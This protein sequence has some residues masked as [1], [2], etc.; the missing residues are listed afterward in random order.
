MRETGINIIAEICRALGSKAPLEDLLGTLKQAQVSQLDSMLESQPKASVPRVG[1]RSAASSDVLMSSHDA[2]SALKAQSAEMDA[3]RFA[4]RPRVNLF[5]KL[6]TTDYSTRILLPKWSEKVAALDVLLECGGETPYKLE[7]PGPSISYISLIGEM[8]KLINHTHF[9]VASKSMQV[10]SMLAEGVGEKLYPNLRPLMSTLL[11]L[12]KDKKLTNAVALCLDSFFGSV[13]SIDHLLDKDDSIP[14]QLDE[15]NQKNAVVRSSALEYLGR[16]IKRANDVG[17]RGQLTVQSTKALSLVAVEKLSDTDAK[18]RQAALTLL[19]TLLEL[20]DKEL[21]GTVTSVTEGLKTSNARAYKSLSSATT[22]SSRIGAATKSGATRGTSVSSPSRKTITLPLNQ[23]AKTT[24]KAFSPSTSLVLTTAESSSPEAA[25]LHDSLSRLHSLN[26]PNWSAAEDNGGILAGLKSTQ[27]LHRQC[28]IQSL[29]AFCRSLADGAT[30]TSA[31]LTVVKQYT[32]GFKDSNVNIMKSTFEL[33]V[34]LCEVH[35]K[36]ST[37]F[38]TW[39]CKDGVAAATDKVAD[40]KLAKSATALL[41]EVC[42]VNSPSFVINESFEI[43]E[44]VKSPLVHEA[45]TKWLNKLLLDFGCRALQLNI[46]NVINFLDKECQSANV[47]VKNASLSVAGELHRQYGPSFRAL[48]L[49]K[50]AESSSRNQF[51]AVFLANPFDPVASGKVRPRRCLVSNGEEISGRIGSV[52]TMTLDVPRCDLAGEIGKDCIAKMGSKEGKTA[53]KLRKEALDEVADALGNCNGMLMTT[54]AEMNTLLDLLRALKERLSDSQSNL[55]PLAARV[56][57]TILAAVDKSSQGKLG[58]VVLPSLVGAAMNDSRKPMRDES[59]QAIKIGTKAHDLEGG[60]YHA[61]SLEALVIALVGELKESE[62][63]TAGIPAVLLFLASVA[64]HVPNIDSIMMARAQPLGESFS[65]VMVNGLTS[66]KSETRAAAEILIRA[67]IDHGIISSKTVRA[68][69]QH[70]KPAQQRTVAPIVHKIIGASVP[71]SPRIETDNACSERSKPIEINTNAKEGAGSPRPLTRRQPSS[72]SAPTGLG[73][74]AESTC[75]EVAPPQGLESS[76][77]PLL[78][79][80]TACVQR[81]RR[82]CGKQVSWVEYP[83]EPAGTML[84]STLQSVWSPLIST[85]AQCALF[86]SRGIKKQDDAKDG[87]ELLAKAIEHETKKGGDVVVH[88]LEFVLKWSAFTLC[89]RENPV[90]LHSLLSMLSGLVTFLGSRHRVLTDIEALSLFPYLLEKTSNAKGRFRELFEGLLEKVKAMHVLPPKMFGA[91]VCATVFEKSANARGRVMAYNECAES[92][93]IIGLSG[94][95]KRGLLVV[96]KMVSDEKLPENRSAALDLIFVILGKMDGDT[97]RFARLCSPQ[98]S[99]NSRTLIEE[100]WQKKFPP[101]GTPVGSNLQSASVDVERHG[102]LSRIPSSRTSIVE[103]RRALQGLAER[104]AATHAKMDKSHDQELPRLQLRLKPTD[105]IPS[106]QEKPEIVPTNGPFT[107]S[108]TP[109]M[110]AGGTGYQEDDAE[111]QSISIAVQ[112]ETSPI[113]ETSNLPSGAAAALRARLMKIR[114]KNLT[115]D[116][117][118]HV[119]PIGC[120]QSDHRSMKGDPVSRTTYIEAP[121][122]YASAAGVFEALLA[123]S[124]VTKDD[125]KVQLCIVTLK[126]FHTAISENDDMTERSLREDI[127]QDVAH[128]VERLTRVLTFAFEH[129]DKSENAG[130]CVPLLSVVIATLM[131]LFRDV[132]L[133]PLVSQDSLLVLIKA[134]GYCLLDSR[135]AV[136]ATHLSGLDESTSSQM[137]RGMNKV[138]LWFYRRC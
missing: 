94:I 60:E 44:R 16:C 87:C 98:M 29:N 22:T 47:K 67:F 42:V 72:Q 6:G 30:Q 18:V 100:R 127:K 45:Y 126:R 103:R 40:K 93:G 110:L 85:E 104:S 102:R 11:Q 10:L 88:Q 96:A 90:G 46:A 73:S 17:K 129:G 118:P 121:E 111:T 50:L 5:S 120:E 117:K 38:P 37:A 12:G 84:M 115:K 105:S 82:L 65:T 56:I 52:A 80:Q 21:H 27:W 15:K 125:P 36:T 43:M 35:A 123:S 31:V 133:A 101:K 78:V 68:G 74:G 41:T 114:Q 20:Q 138:S 75:G 128:C 69:L 79:S 4:N 134:T 71:K 2:L 55:K 92:V 113:H 28:A 77:H 48:A 99:D 107:F 116:S 135:L 59:L 81:S 54:S 51:E 97:E 122:N 70:L 14:S 9:A 61:Q 130:M 64:K 19:Q 8:R 119:P 136:A 63:K 53:W 13:L 34:T 23:H 109:T 49:S 89:S 108:Y 62:F 86:P 3:Q 106:H 66:S 124:N 24:P 112:A 26:I 131:A 39:A 7:F 57:G 132:Q 137:V 91:V 83:E 76:S 33:F 95:G 32:K 25:D 58:K 1:L